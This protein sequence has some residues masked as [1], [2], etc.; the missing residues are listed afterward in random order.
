MGGMCLWFEVVSKAIGVAMVMNLIEA[1][2]KQVTI[3]VVDHEECGKVIRALRQDAG[4]TQ[5][6]LAAKIGISLAYV[7]NLERGKRAWNDM[8]FRKA[9]VATTE[10]RRE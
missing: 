8:L 10:S 1:F 9:L 3:T 6:E 4:M 5:G 7:S 2:R